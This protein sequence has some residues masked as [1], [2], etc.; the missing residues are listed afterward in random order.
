MSKTILNI[1]NSFVTFYNL[2]NDQ[3]ADYF[4]TD[5]E[6][7]IQKDFCYPIYDEKDLA[8]QVSIASTEVLT[9]SNIVPYIINNAGQGQTLNDVIIN[10][11]EIGTYNGSV[12]IYNIYFKYFGSDLTSGLSDGDCFTLGAA[13]GTIEAELIFIVSNQCFKKITDKCLT[14]QLKYIN[15]DDAFGFSYRAF[16][17]FPNL[18]FTQNVI[19]LPIYFKEPIVTSDKTVY[20]RSNGTRELLSAR[21]SKQFKGYID[22]VGEDVHQ[23]LVVALNN[24][25]VVFVPENYPNTTGMQVRFEDEYN[26]EFPTIMQNVNVWPADFTIFETPFNNFN[27]NCG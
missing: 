19:R 21:L 16:G 15:S 10:V 1:D 6:C 5:T 18:T 2:V 20:V 11:D 17:T 13:L 24:D 7:G 25:A 8:F 9:T 27:S 3:G 26:N 12:P 23:K 4:I 22:M 14:S